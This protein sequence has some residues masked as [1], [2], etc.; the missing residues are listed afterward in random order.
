MF[1]KEIM[2]HDIV[3][4]TPDVF[5]Q[6]AAKTMTKYKIGG[7]VVVDEKEKLIGMVTERDILSKIVAKDED[8]AILRVSDIMTKD[9][10]TIQNDDEVDEAVELM[11]KNKIKKIPVL[12]EEKIVGIIT[13]SDIIV[14]QPKMIA[15]LCDLLQVKTEKYTAS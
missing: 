5:V 12:H 2:N 11:V 14:I 3:C 9:P 7:L 6:E 15:K 8:P 13:T 4:I 10:V 1:V